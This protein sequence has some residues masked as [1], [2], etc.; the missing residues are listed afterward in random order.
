M[1]VFLIKKTHFLLFLITFCLLLC[2]LAGQGRGDSRPAAGVAPLPVSS[3]LVVIIDP[4]HGGPDGGA[5]SP[6]GIQESNINLA[7]AFRVR[8][9]LALMG[10]GSQMTRT[11]DISVHTPG[12]ERWK[13]SDLQNRA[14][15]VNETKE[16]VLLSIHQN[17]LP[18]S[19]ITHGAQ[20]FYN[21]TPRAEQ[22]SAAIQQSL[23]ET[24]N[25]GNE[26]HMKPAPKGIYLM[27]HISAP[28]ILV[29]CGFLS[30][31]SETQ[32]LQTT[33]HQI[34]L[35]SAITIGFLRGAGEDIT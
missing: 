32:A 33:A 17:S 29:E 8:D 7:L 10:Q 12:A 35:A 9:L 31:A 15:M 26:K 21:T 22:I 2:S 6:D 13:A 20:V 14:A 4:G 1:L 30:N 25:I 24:I 19:P 28:G 5:V 11:E 3:P 34:K 23:N 27:K 16:G 18:S